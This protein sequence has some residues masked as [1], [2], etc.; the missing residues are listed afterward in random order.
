MRGR[1]LF[2]TLVGGCAA[3]VMAASAAWACTESA[4]LA[5]VGANSGAVGSTVTV[6]AKHFNAA[7]VDVRWGGPAGPVVAVGQGPEFTASF[8]VPADATAGVHLIVATQADSRNPAT[9]FKV[10][11]SSPTASSAPE[12]PAPSQPAPT[13]STATEEPLPE[14]FIPRSA[15]PVDEP[16]APV[17]TATGA[18][19]IAPAA[20]TATR[21]PVASAAPAATSA[22]TAQPAPEATVAE[23]VATPSRRTAADDV[24][25]GFSA[26]GRSTA[27]SLETPAPA[28]SG[29]SAP[30]LLLLAAGFGGLAA[31]G[32]AVQRRRSRA[33]R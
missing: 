19:A 20:R 6:D 32:L 21:A 22:A 24:W 2:A 25:S 4:D 10:T 14:P 30:A 23:A 31:G 33:V 1:R 18:T 7:R 28:D 26:A 17:A 13:A 3:A 11:S 29:S 27:P 16:T 9:T 15:D 8:A 5:T 12:A